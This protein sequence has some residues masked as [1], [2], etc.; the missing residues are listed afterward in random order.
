MASTAAPNHRYTYIEVMG[1]RAACGKMVA[2][3]G[4]LTPLASNADEKFSPS[5]YLSMHQTARKGEMAWRSHH[6]SHRFP[7]VLGQS[8]GKVKEEDGVLTLAFHNLWAESTHVCLMP[9]FVKF[10]A[11]SICTLSI[12]KVISQ[13][14]ASKCCD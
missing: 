4:R 9:D 11:K 1:E 6:A 3:C 14:M 13:Q 12:T 8:K 2:I 5:L 10:N 7:L